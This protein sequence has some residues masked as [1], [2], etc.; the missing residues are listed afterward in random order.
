MTRCARRAAAAILAPAF[1][2]GCSW[3]DFERFDRETRRPPSSEADAG[4]AP[5]PGAGGRGCPAD[6]PKV[7]FCSSFDGAAVEAG[8]AR[9]ILKA[10][11]AGDT[12]SLDALHVW[13]PPRSA[14]L[15]VAQSNE[16]YAILF[17]RLAP[18]PRVAAFTAFAHVYQEAPPP[19]RVGVLSVSELDHA[20]RV[21]LRHTATDAEL[22]YEGD[23]LVVAPLRDPLPVG[24]F[25]S[26]AI[27]RDE[28][29]R[30]ASVDIDGVP[31]M[32]APLVLPGSGPS[33]PVIELRV[34]VLYAE[35]STDP[36][37]VWVDDVGLRR[38]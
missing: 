26:V 10:P 15:A 37:T 6:D 30:E 32:D 29:A 25:F 8:F 36:V 18:S 7:L 34:G 17:A 24:R 31:A 3:T 22:V 16:R 1:F 23:V 20:S 9:S 38:R 4:D 13:S 2:A 11:D 19:G 33:S 28:A 5:I 14:R 21:A 12:A 35:R 27:H